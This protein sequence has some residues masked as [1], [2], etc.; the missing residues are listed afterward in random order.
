MSSPSI[1]KL[2]HATFQQ[3][4][5]IKL[6]NVVFISSCQSG[7]FQSKPIFQAKDRNTKIG[8]YNGRWLQSSSHSNEEALPL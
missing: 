2:F 5:A 6:A 8:I 4:F 1:L 3:A 7:T